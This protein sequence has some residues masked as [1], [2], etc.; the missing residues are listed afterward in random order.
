MGKTE[1]GMTENKRQGVISHNLKS[2]SKSFNCAVLALAQLN[3]Q[4]EGQDN[5]RPTLKD[6]RDSGEIEENAD[7]VMFIHSPDY[8][9]EN[10]IKETKR[11]IQVWIEKNRNGQRMIR[12]SL[13][14]DMIKQRFYPAEEVRH[15]LNGA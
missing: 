2:L 12:V 14:Y 13:L 1:K 6:L 3:R 15:N 7:I 11:G 9:D 8:Y 4:V 10:K 5:K